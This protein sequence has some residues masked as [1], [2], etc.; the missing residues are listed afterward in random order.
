MGNG[1]QAAVHFSSACGNCVQIKQMGNG[2]QSAT[3]TG[4][5]SSNGGCGLEL[6]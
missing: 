3:Q 2:K 4:G 1:K 6:A 5:E